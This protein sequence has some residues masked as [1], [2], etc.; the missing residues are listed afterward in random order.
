MLAG[1]FFCM[2]G[3]GRCDKCVAGVQTAPHEH[4]TLQLVEELGGKLNTVV[5]VV[6]DMKEDMKREAECS[7]CGADR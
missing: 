1:I 3:G 7:F 6:R 4:V 5:N 2:G